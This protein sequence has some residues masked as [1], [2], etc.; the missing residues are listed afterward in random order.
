MN[1]KQRITN[2]LYDLIKVCSLSD[3]QNDDWAELSRKFGNEARVFF[4]KL[5]KNKTI[6]TDY[7][8]IKIGRD[9]IIEIK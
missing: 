6:E 8:T 7:K 2:E 3:K 4:K 9:I 5:L 1:K